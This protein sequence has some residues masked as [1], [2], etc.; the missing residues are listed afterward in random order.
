[1]PRLVGRVGTPTDKVGAGPLL[2][3]LYPNVTVG[4]L[5]IAVVGTPVAP[6]GRGIHA[7]AVMAQGSATV[8]VGPAKT[9]VCGTG[10]LA[11]CAE[12]LIVG[13]SAKVYIG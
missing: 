11:S 2:K 8:W 13:P 4:G 1:M 3:P 7:T 9:P 10:H 12:P 6:H 5:P